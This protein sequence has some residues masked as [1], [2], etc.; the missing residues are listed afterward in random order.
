VLLYLFIKSPEGTFSTTPFIANLD[1]QDARRPSPRLP[2]VRA[3]TDVQGLVLS[4]PALSRLDQYS[5][6]FS[7]L[8]LSFSFHLLVSIAS[9][10]FLDALHTATIALNATYCT[11]LHGR[12]PIVFTTPALSL[13][14]L[15]LSVSRFV[16]KR[17]GS[18]S[19]NIGSLWH[20]SSS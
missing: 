1:F 12:R 10:R 14:L 5:T 3:S 4:V 15:A 13:P 8:I 18:G 19:G 20:S 9:D 16:P 11:V 17:L 6:G 2:R 7:S